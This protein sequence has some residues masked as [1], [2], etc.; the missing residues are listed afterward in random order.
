[1]SECFI[2]F[3]FKQKTAYDLRMR[4]WSSDVCSSDLLQDTVTFG[5]RRSVFCGFERMAPGKHAIP[6]TRNRAQSRGFRT[7]ERRVGKECVSTGR[8]RW[9]PY[10]YT[11]NKNM[12][13]THSSFRIC[14]PRLTHQYSYT[15]KSN[16][17]H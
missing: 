12:I 15:T 13:Q 3:F 7:E 4:D 10:H 6:G 9:L 14:A 5:T 1:M 2:C 17:S 11:K 16:T 8:S